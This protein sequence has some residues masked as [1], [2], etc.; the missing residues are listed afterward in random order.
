MNKRFRISDFLKV[1]SLFGSIK[2]VAVHIFLLLFLK[3]YLDYHL[4][5]LGSQLCYFFTRVS[6]CLFYVQQKVRLFVLLQ[7]T[8]R[9][10]ALCAAESA[11]ICLMQPIAE[12]AIDCSV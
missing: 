7:Q 4:N 8:L 12:G 11:I 2:R 3:L 5:Y 1:L 10:F 9:L 6:Y